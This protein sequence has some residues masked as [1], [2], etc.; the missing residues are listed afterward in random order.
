MQHS[1]V[2]SSNHEFKHSICAKCGAPMW[3]TRIEPYEPDHD[4]RMFECQACSNTIIEI[5][6][7]R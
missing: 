5:V 6:K 3:L 4:Q 2:A 7:Y 1:Y